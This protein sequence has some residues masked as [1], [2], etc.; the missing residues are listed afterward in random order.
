MEGIPE[1]T[2]GGKST[3]NCVNTF[4]PRIYKQCIYHMSCAF[5][6]YSFNCFFCGLEILV[7]YIHEKEKSSWS[8]HKMP[9]VIARKRKWSGVST[10]GFIGTSLFEEKKSEDDC[11]INVVAAVVSLCILL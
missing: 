8:W 6:S 4:Y 7:T 11:S 3:C 10:M 2:F 1:A 9:K 5:C